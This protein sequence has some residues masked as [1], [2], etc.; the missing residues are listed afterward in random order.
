MLYKLALKSFP[1]LDD[2]PGQTKPAQGVLRMTSC[3]GCEWHF[4]CNR[5]EI[6]IGKGLALSC[7]SSQDLLE[8]FPS[9][10][11]KEGM[12]S[13]YLKEDTFDQ[14]K[15]GTGRKGFGNQ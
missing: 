14:W 12:C 2:S 10:N 3:N 13:T 8:H 6:I 11:E 15:I 4:I 1:F 7:H 9:R 5:K